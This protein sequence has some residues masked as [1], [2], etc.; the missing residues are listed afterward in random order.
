MA[1]ISTRSNPTNLIEID[2]TKINIA[3]SETASQRSFRLEKLDV[4]KLDLPAESRVVCVARAGKTSRRFEMGT[5]ENWNRDEF[6]LDDLDRSEV[7][8]FRILVHG[9]TDPQLLASAENLRPK[10]EGESESL[11]PMEPADLGQLIWRLDMTEEGPVLRFNISVFPSAA[12]T[13]NYRPFGAFVLPE[14]LRQVLRFISTH[15]DRLDDESDP[16]HLWKPWLDSLGAGTVP[17]TDDS[18]ADE[19][20]DSIV[21]VFCRK[22]RFASQMAHLLSLGGSE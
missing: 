18:D 15:P 5:I 8:R 6:A 20:C 3:V 10:N 7:L 21:D 1:R 22:H 16:L 11:L 13:E 14:A 2:K 17:G 12:G 4:T 19:W 9:A